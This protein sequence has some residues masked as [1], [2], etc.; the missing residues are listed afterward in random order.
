MYCSACGVAVAQGTSYCNYCGATLNGVKDDHISSEVK[1]G[2]LVCAMV[3]VFVL[4]LAAITVLTGMMKAVLHLNI[5]LISAFALLSFLIM[6]LIEGVC[7]WLL[8]RGHRGA[9]KAGDLALSK[10]RATK[11]LDAA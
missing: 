2:L 4:G 9:K 6:L 5:G 8:V 3:A 10:K 1:P 7:I 11:E